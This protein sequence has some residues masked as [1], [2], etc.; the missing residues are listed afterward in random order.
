MLTAEITINAPP[1]VVRDIVCL[2]VSTG[3]GYRSSS[4]KFFDF[5]NL[6]QWH[7]KSFFSE[8]EIT[9]PGKTTGAQLVKGDKV[10]IV[11]PGG[12]F[13]GVIE[14]SHASHTSL[15]VLSFLSLSVTVRGLADSFHR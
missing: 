6:S 11:I 2:A 5:N 12:T 7:D 4:C 1:Q 14:V 15:L 10:K 13:P 9:T 3:V 8:I